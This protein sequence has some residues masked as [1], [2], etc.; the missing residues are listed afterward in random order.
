MPHELDNRRRIFNIGDEV[1]S[2]GRCTRYT[3]AAQLPSLPSWNVACIID[4]KA[5]Q[6]TFRRS[7]PL[8]L[9]LENCYGDERLGMVPETADRAKKILIGSGW[10]IHRRMKDQTIRGT[11]HSHQT[12]APCTQELETEADFV[13]MSVLPL[14]L[15]TFTSLHVALSL[16]RHG[17]ISSQL[18]ISPEWGTSPFWNLKNRQNKVVADCLIGWWTHHQLYPLQYILPLIIHG[19]AFSIHCEKQQWFHH[20]F[21]K[22]A[23]IASGSFAK[24]VLIFAIFSRLQTKVLALDALTLL[25]PILSR[26]G[27]LWLHRRCQRPERNNYLSGARHFHAPRKLA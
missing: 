21:D 10:V 13:V 26:N 25:D 3:S 4:A 1:Q 20:P 5:W 12:M 16:A 23:L 11:V 2:I 27:P 7:I 17:P 8:M 6:Q 22:F 18:N 24:S 15:G 14:C 9:H 19:L